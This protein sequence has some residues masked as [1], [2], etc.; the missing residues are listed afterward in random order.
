MLSALTRLLR[1]PSPAPQ[2]QRRRRGRRS[3][4][5]ATS[6]AFTVP[7]PTVVPGVAIFFSESASRSSSRQDHLRCVA[8]L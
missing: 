3:T 5:T 1:G 4:P 2:R 7:V 8:I 6:S